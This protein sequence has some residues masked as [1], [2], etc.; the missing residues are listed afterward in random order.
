MKISIRLLLV[1]V[2]VFQYISLQ[3]QGTIDP[4]S[5]LK[6]TITSNSKIETGLTYSTGE[7]KTLFS[8]KIDFSKLRFTNELSVFDILQGKI[9]GLDIISAS[10]NPGRNSQ[11]ILRGQ[12]SPLIVINGI[13]QKSHDELF[14]AF[15]FYGEDIRSM[16]PV[17]VEDIKSIEVLK[18]GSAT[19]LYGADGAGGVIL[20]ETKKGSWQKMG[21]TYQFNQSIINEPSSIPMLNGDE[22]ISYQLDALHN[23]YNGVF[24]TPDE[25]SNNRDNPNYYNYSANT[26]WQKA[27]TQMGYASNHYLNIFGGNE[28][29]RY[30]G[31]VN[32]LD[33]KGT[34]INTGYKRLLSRLNFEHY[35][36]KKLTLAINLNYTNSKYNENVIPEDD[37]GN[38]GKNIL[39]MAFIKA[40]N[41]SIWEYD[42][43]GNRTGAYFTPSQNYQGSGLV[44]Y[45]PVAVSESGNST[46]TFNELTTTAYLQYDFKSWLKFR[47]SFSYNRYT[48]VSKAFLP[49]SAISSDLFYASSDLNG[50]SDLGFD[51]FRNEIQTFIKIPFKDEKKNM[52]NGTF[53]W[54]RQNEKY[55]DYRSETN[56]R[57]IQISFFDKNRNAA[58]SSVYY[59]LLDRYMLNVNTRI[60]SVSIDSQDKNKWD[61]H[62]SISTGWRFSGESFIKKLKFLNEG[63]IHAGWSSSKYQSM[64]NYSYRASGSIPQSSIDFLYNSFYNHNYEIKTYNLGIELGLFHDR[65]HLTSDYYSRTNS[66][67]SDLP[68]I[69]KVQ[70]KGWEFMVDYSLIR[71][72]N[73]DWT[74]QFNMAHNSQMFLEL[75]DNI[76]GLSTLSNGNFVS[77]ISVNESPGSIHGLL[78]E[79]VYSTDQD[80]VATNKEGNMLVDGSGTPIKL[81]YKGIYTFKGGDAKY[82]DMNNDGLI[83]EKD[84]VNLGNSNPKVTGGFGSTIRF[85]NLSLTCNFHYRSGY[86]IIN[87][88]AM[89]SEGLSYLNNQSKN[90]LNRWMVDGQQGTDIL[91]RAYSNHPANN[92]GSDRY[93]ENGSYIRMNYISLGYQIKPEFCQKLKIKELFFSLSAQRLLTF[94]NY[95]GSDPETEKRNN[96]LRLFDKD[97]IR[98]IPPKIFTMSIRITV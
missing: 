35:F 57:I 25:I 5:S 64:D 18:D 7:N 55:E 2:A 22:Y 42:A 50:K 94:S 81:S 20:I 70:N 38:S 97:E 96:D 43:E 65:V 54:I 98:V 17:S 27:V 47:E 93:V 89:N 91:P 30:Y 23:Y 32:Y 68:A 85:K 69:F 59:K 6:D 73:L 67:G 72:E 24:E 11:A 92:L 19:A 26:N 52:L 78:Y 4:E 14:N 53:T 86:K 63:I 74:V 36:T 66:Y 84:L 1:I 49:S 40:P 34:I 45:N 13:P 90:E 44:Y 12:N 31:S 15:N 61:N 41:M 8:T 46:S 60:E 83:D 28:K 37:A 95:S 75:P 82:K 76:S 29:N 51:E 39:E 21:L 88:V 9:S 3:A 16:I 71:K 77:Y 58:V 56:K 79:G 33:Q 87:Q 10:G 62:C 80:A 48:A